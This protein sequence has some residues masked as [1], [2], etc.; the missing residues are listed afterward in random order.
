M[1]IIQTPK[2]IQP[3]QVEGFPDDAKRSVKGALHIFPGATKEITEDEYAVI[4]KKYPELSEKLRVID[5]K[6]K[7]SVDDNEE[8]RDELE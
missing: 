8:E 7:K 4:Q 5:L 6:K 3:I 1:L 2:T